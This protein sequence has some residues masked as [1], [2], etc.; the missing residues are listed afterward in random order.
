MMQS[1]FN[2]QT[3]HPRNPPPFY[4]SRKNQES[5]SGL[6]RAIAL[7]RGEYSLILARC[8]SPRLRQQVL[9]Q[10]SE[11]TSLALQEVNL[12]PSVVNLLDTLEGVVRSSYSDALI[13]KGLEVV[14]NLELLLEEANFIRNAFNQSLHLPVVL[15]VNEK[16][17]RC[18]K[19]VAPDFSNH[20]AISI[21]FES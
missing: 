11:S 4:G 19:R 15:W 18:M 14:V 7:A 10:I 6:K 12:H 13:V 9:K 5:L 2:R 1:L 21:G 20:G 16:T 3:S 8:E 17:L